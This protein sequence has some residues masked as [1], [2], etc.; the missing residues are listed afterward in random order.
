MLHWNKSGKNFWER[1]LKSEHSP[2]IQ[3]KK[4]TNLIKFFGK[5]PFNKILDALIDNIWE[6]YSK[7]EIQGLAGISKATLFNHWAK[8][9]KVNLVKVTRVFGKTKLYALNTK[10]PLIKDILK[11]E[12]RMIEETI[13]KEKIAVKA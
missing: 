6:D 8:L 12:A 3:M 9:E 2:L 4:E 10:S 13:P 5:N 11:F 1:R 7:K